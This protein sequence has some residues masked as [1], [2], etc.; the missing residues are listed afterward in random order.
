MSERAPYA[1]AAAAGVVIVER[2]RVAQTHWSR[3]KGLLGTKNLPAGD[4]LW[5]APCNQ[6]H[7]IGM[8][9]PIDIVFLDAERRVLRT[10]SGLQPGRISPRVAG[11][12]SVLELPDGTLA[13]AALVE[14][15]Q[16]DIDG[17]DLPG[18]RSESRV[19]TF[20]A[21]GGNVLLAGLYLGFVT[22]HI[23]YARRTGQWATAMP[24]VVQESMLMTLF[25]TRRRSVATSNRPYDW[26]VG[27]VGVL[28]PL[29]MRPT[30]AVSSI[31]WIGQALQIVG[32]TLAAV[33]L[34]FLGRSLG[35]VAAN[36]GIKMAGM[37]RLLRH[38]MY[39]AY[40]LSYVGY[41]LTCPT[42][43]NAVLMA[44]TLVALNARAIVEERFLARDSL[45]RD[46]LER[47]PWRFVPYVY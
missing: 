13:R 19:A 43:R 40:M 12:R 11:A 30:D 4:G 20:N 6:V 14:G 45:Y 47:T 33:A 16:L 8:R 22:A 31:A 24:L 17:D 10:I 26:A 36:R 9:Y 32:L 5:L 21:W 44:A 2:L 34:G 41:V 37:Y 18:L 29:L 25:L 1:R 15:M 7:M 23:A 28:L 3:F 46:Y 27:I 38:P 35:I 42:L 39:A